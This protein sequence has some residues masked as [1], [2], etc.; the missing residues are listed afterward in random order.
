MLSAYVAAVAV[1]CTFRY[2]SVPRLN[3]A[4]MIVSTNSSLRHKARS[5]ERPNNLNINNVDTSDLAVK[6]A[7]LKRKGILR[8]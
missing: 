5:A 2:A 4:L 6:V 3:L 8:F 7:T 1:V